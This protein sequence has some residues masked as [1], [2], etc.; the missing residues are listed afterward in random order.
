MKINQYNLDEYSAL[1]FD[2][3]GTLINSMPLHNKAWKDAFAAN[4]VTITEEFLQETAGM[5]SVRIVEIVNERFNIELDPKA[6]ARQKRNQYLS[7]L[8]KVEVVAPLLEILKKYKDKKPMGIITAS[9]H[10][11]VDQLLPKL[12][13]EHYFQ[14]I[15]CADDTQLGKDTTEPYSL[16]S[17]QLGTQM[18]ECIFFDDGDVG[19]K[20]AR[21]SGMDVVHV[22]ITTPEVFKA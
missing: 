11:V 1:L 9:S 15:I 22:D 10:E 17:E 19:L 5:K 13:I 7:T 4:G 12:G 3:D 14:S 6:V 20:G 2:L 21:L 8:H 18:K 16:A